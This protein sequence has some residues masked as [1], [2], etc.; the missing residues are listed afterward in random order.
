[1]RAALDLTDNLEGTIYNPSAVDKLTL[2][3]RLVAY[4]PFYRTYTTLR[5]HNI[6]G[7]APLPTCTTSSSFSRTRR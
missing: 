2:M 6:H 1:M 4:H 7:H 3:P 5:P